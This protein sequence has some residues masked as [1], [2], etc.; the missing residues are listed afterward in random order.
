MD[1]LVEA[2][3]FDV[4]SPLNSAHTQRM[5]PFPVV[6]AL[7]NTW[8]HVGT[9]NSGNKTSDI[10]PPIDEALCFYTTLYILYVDPNNDHIGFRRYLNNSWFQC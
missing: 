3:T 1:G 9:I 7:G 2:I 10:E 4:F 8:V 5:T 6:F